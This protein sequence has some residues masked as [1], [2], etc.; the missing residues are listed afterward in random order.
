MSFLVKHRLSKIFQPLNMPAKSSKIT[1]KSLKLMLDLGFIQNS[2]PGCFNFLPLGIKS[3]QKLTK[4]IDE[5]MSNIGGQKM[6]FPSLINTKL[7][8]DSGRLE[9]AG[10]ELFKL[11]DRHQKSYILSPTHEEVATEMLSTLSPLSYREF[12]LKFYQI[13]T[14]F[15]DE[16]KPRFGLMRGREFIMKDMY[17]FDIDLNSA[18][19]TY[20]EV[21]ESYEN[22][23]KTIGMDFV[24]VLGNSGLMGGHLSHEYQFKSSI[25]EDNLLHC[26]SCD[27]Y[28][29]AE[30][31]E[32]R[33]KCPQCGDSNKIKVHSGIEVGH[34]FLLGEK[35]SKL[36]NTKYISMNQESKVLQMGSYGLGI[37]RMLAACLEVLSTDSDMR[38]PNSI[39]PYNIIILPAKEGSKEETLT[40]G[41]PEKVYSFLEERIPD[42]RDN[43][44]LDDRTGLTIGRR[45][46]EAKRVGYPFIVVINKR[47][48]ED[49]SLVEL[50]HTKTKQTMYLTY[51]ALLDYIKQNVH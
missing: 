23:F 43:I 15:R 12:P 31:C 44:L 29:N 1:S 10:P 16:I 51:E 6:L 26:E 2:V 24:K 3:L 49:S 25:G 22:I 32:D 50:F 18:K 8:N 7:W 14:K 35:Y 41:V 39:A 45:L 48:S 34:T 42:L 21:C 19:K 36:L 40:K 33:S 20:E 17:T 11:Q 38:W 28:V 46:L 37:S 27:Y 9:E 47:T 30:L 4:I 5:E 13:S